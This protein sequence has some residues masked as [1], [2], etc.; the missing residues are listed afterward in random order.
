M[1]QSPKNPVFLLKSKQYAPIWIYNKGNLDLKI[2]S[3]FSFGS[4]NDPCAVAHNSV[5]TACHLSTFSFG[6]WV[7]QIV[8]LEPIAC[9][10]CSHN[11]HRIVLVLVSLL[12]NGVM[13]DL[14]PGMLIRRDSS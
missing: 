10:Q 6:G 4:R 7:A 9:A 1:L 11:M 13:P 5:P 3:H 14:P 12:W 8:F 2:A